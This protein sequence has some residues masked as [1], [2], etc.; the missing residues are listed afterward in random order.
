MDVRHLKWAFLLS[1]VTAL[2]LTI[3]ITLTH[4]QE[5]G[6]VQELTG[7]AEVG[8]SVFYTIPGL[9][10][11]QTLYVYVAG[12]SGNL[13]PVA[14]LADVRLESETLNEAFW[15]KVERVMA[16]GRDPLEALPGIYDE[17]L[18]IWDDDS[19]V[20]YDAAFEADYPRVVA[21]L[22]P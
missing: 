6:S 1:I 18:V 14:A 19:G 7:R 12:T 15:G 13:D 9:K 16:Q 10:Q 2:S 21:R 3:G 4:A 22:V 17:L 11:G 20:G 8:D 5:S